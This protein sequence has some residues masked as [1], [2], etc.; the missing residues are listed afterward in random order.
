MYT[1]YLYVHKD[2]PDMSLLEDCYI[3]GL[4]IIPIYE[5]LIGW[6]TGLN[7]K[8]PFLPLLMYST[9]CAIGVLYCFIRYYLYA[10]ELNTMTTKSKTKTKTLKNIETSTAT[11]WQHVKATSETETLSQSAAKT[12]AKPVTQLKSKQKLK[13]HK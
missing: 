2:Y 13:K 7:E 4:V 6:L 12:K 8:L 11:A 5:H 1:R 10:L 3:H 9:Y